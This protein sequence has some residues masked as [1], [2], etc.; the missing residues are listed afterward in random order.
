MTF[1]VVMPG[2]PNQG[3]FIGN[4]AECLRYIMAQGIRRHAWLE[5]V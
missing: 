4:R 5:L 2:Y 3:Y 1:I